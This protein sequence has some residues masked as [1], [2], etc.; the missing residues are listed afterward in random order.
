M[1]T[2]I[3]FK[4]EESISFSS[5]IH[6]HTHTHTTYTKSFQGLKAHKQTTL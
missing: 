2:R 6:T 1:N 5:M 4:Q 3:L